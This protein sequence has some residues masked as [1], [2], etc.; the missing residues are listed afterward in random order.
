VV[1]YVLPAHL[2]PDHMAKC[3][4]QVAP[5]YSFQSLKLIMRLKVIEIPSMDLSESEK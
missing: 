3:N 1:S 5:G 2:N 4:E